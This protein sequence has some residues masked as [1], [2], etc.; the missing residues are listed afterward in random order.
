MSDITIIRGS[1]YSD[2]LQ[3]A[4]GECILLKVKVLPDAPA[5]LKCAGH[6][7]PDGW[8]CT[9]EG[10]PKI[11]ENQEFM[12]KVVDADTLVIPCLNGMSFGFARD[13]VL[14]TSAPV[15]M[16]GY[17]ARM[18][19]R[20]PT[21]KELLIELTSDNGLITIDNVNKRIGRTISS[22]ITAA[23]TWTEGE[24]DLEMYQGSYVVKIDHGTVRVEQEVTV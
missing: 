24:F 8:M 12:V 23:I 10:H 9:I 1:T 13:A 11:D 4:T 22:T 15:N 6:T 21:T 14:R 2:T 17:G 18:Q 16:D 7:L 20:N 5:L 3:W 19:I